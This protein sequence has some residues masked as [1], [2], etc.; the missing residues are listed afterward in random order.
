MEPQLD[1][2]SNYCEEPDIGVNSVLL[3]S[4][5]TQWPNNMESDDSEDDDMLPTEEYWAIPDDGWTL[6]EKPHAKSRGVR[7][8][9][10]PSY[11]ALD[12]R[13][14]NE[15]TCYDAL[16]DIVD[17]TVLSNYQK[18][19]IQNT[20]T[21]VEVSSDNRTVS[22]D[23]K[24]AV[25][26]QPDRLIVSPMDVVKPIV[27][28]QPDRLIGLPIVNTGGRDDC[29]RRMGQTP[30][31]KDNDSDDVTE[32]VGEL[33][34]VS[35]VVVQHK[36]AEEVII[37]EC[38]AGQVVKIETTKPT[39]STELVN[40]SQKRITRGFL[41][42]A[43]EARRV[44]VG[45][46]PSGCTDENEQQ[47]PEIR[48]PMSMDISWRIGEV[49]DRS[50]DSLS[51][52]AIRMPT[53]KFEEGQ[54]TQWPNGKST[55]MRIC[56]YTLE[57]EMFSHGP[58]WR[59]AEPVFVAAESEVF[60]PVCTGE[61]VVET[62]PLVVAEAVTSRVSALPTVGSDFQTGLSTA[63]GREDRYILSSGNILD[64]V[65]HVAG[66]LKVC[67]VPVEDLLLFSAVYFVMPSLLRSLTVQTST[68]FLS[69]EREEVKRPLSIREDRPV[70][71]R[72][73][74]IHEVDMHAQMTKEIHGVGPNGDRWDGID[75]IVD[76]YMGCVWMKS[77]PGNR[78]R[79]LR[80]YT[81]SEKFGLESGPAVRT[82]PSVLD[83]DWLNGHPNRSGC[84]I[85]NIRSAPI[86]DGSLSHQP[87][88]WQYTSV[89]S[90]IFN[91]L[92]VRL[93]M[94]SAS[95]LKTVSESNYDKLYDLPAGIQ[96]VM[97]L[98]A[99]HP[100]AAVCKVMSIPDSNCVR[101]I[102]P[103]EHVP[104][105]FHEILIDD[106][107][108]KEWPKVPL[109]EIGCLRLDWPHELFTFVGRY[110]LE[111]EQM[112]KECR[113]RFEGISSGACPTC[114]KF[115]QNNLGR[116]VAMYH[117]D[118]AQLW[119]CPVG[120]CPVWKGTSQDCIDH[121]RR[122]HNT[123]ILMKAGNLARW[124]PPWTV[125]REQWHNM[126]RPTVSGIAIDTFLFS[127]IGMPLFHR[128][129]VFDRFGSHPAFRKPYMTNI[130]LFLNTGYV[131]RNSH[132]SPGML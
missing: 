80:G 13:V 111:L 71:T 117:L 53:V 98:Q 42:L 132:R 55:G 113:D 23:V 110:Q 31:D 81:C 121:M 106:M 103:D 96:D 67:T 85:D 102:T 79:F 20:N 95:F 18:K 116:H 11:N 105:G 12:G 58:V 118:L 57:S 10:Q 130:F 75:M 61:F 93:E 65:G 21:M 19:V 109:S 63:V 97:G 29:L 88:L 129:R 87:A 4:L 124:F 17:N 51:D 15:R 62:D 104:T 119:R 36:T 43:E 38:P 1:D 27:S 52:V 89:F 45:L 25:N 92:V 125:T 54:L 91:S 73:L 50:V 48:E 22:V 47:R 107:G 82:G 56:E 32:Q 9:H 30:R 6:V 46:T 127:R 112:R 84:L 123:P 64:K 120:W 114:E 44:D 60:T 49:V 100:S 34:P 5:G 39:V 28:D 90:C 99:L 126:S 70:K 131:C 128:Y 40:L 66:Q 122:A 76:W 77:Q 2:Y 83:L 33:L 24:P 108:L 94:S 14:I 59:E 74:Y 37:V 115:I 26:K 72:R 68:F 86:R 3:N 7:F 41:E 69:D 16:D 8:G 35:R 101:V 78:A